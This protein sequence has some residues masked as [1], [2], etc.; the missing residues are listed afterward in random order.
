LGILIGP[1]RKISKEGGGTK[2]NVAQSL[3]A[4]FVKKDANGSF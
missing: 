3:K 1:P 2:I 4:T